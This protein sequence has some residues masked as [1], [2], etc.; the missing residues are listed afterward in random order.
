[1]GLCLS[2]SHP[3]SVV[4]EIL[5]FRAISAWVSPSFRRRSRSTS[6]NFISSWAGALLCIRGLRS[7]L[8]EYNLACKAVNG[9]GSAGQPDVVT[10]T[11]NQAINRFLECV[12]G[13]VGMH[14]HPTIAVVGLDPRWT[15]D[16]HDHMT[17]IVPGGWMKA[18]SIASSTSP[19]P[20]THSRRSGASAHSLVDRPEYRER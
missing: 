3:L 9:F 2:V 8:S 13:G 12:P 18:G 6:E 16:I 15:L 5:S 7:T 14:V 10:S 11:S 19:A 17:C 1:M 4:Q 20:G